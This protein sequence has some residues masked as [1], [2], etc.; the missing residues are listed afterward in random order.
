GAANLVAFNISSKDA[1]EL[2]GEFDIT[3][4]PER[5]EEI[6][7]EQLIGQR[8][9]RTY[10]YDVTGHLLRQGHDDERVTVFIKKYLQEL[11]L[12]SL[13]KVER[14]REAVDYTGG[15]HGFVTYRDKTTLPT[16]HLG[17]E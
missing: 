2:A 12:A 13:E 17:I 3:P 14:R 5:I 10:K 4:A 6:E 7:K 11:H 16:N 1:A 8:P 15:K 9:V